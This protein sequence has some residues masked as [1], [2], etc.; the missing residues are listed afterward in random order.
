MVNYLRF[1]NTLKDFTNEANELDLEPVSAL[2]LDEIAIRD[3]QDKPMIV[4][5]VMELTKFGSTATLHR[6]FR[7][8]LNG[9]WVETRYQNG[10]RRTKYIHLT[11]KSK[12]YYDLKGSA[13]KKALIVA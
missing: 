11:N 7:E 1:L 3:M 5:D 2:I 9:A 13:M 6:K 4:S 8:M 12:T 10:N